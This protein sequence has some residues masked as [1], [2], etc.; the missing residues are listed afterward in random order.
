MDPSILA[1]VQFLS[2]KGEVQQIFAFKSAP[3]YLFGD[4]LL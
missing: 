1:P 2:G 4:G 3:L